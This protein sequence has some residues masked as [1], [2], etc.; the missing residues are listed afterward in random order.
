MNQFKTIT[1]KDGSISLD[2]RVSVE[3]G[4]IWLSAMDLA[5]LLNINVSTVR[6]YINL[7]YT[8]NCILPEQISANSTHFRTFLSNTKPIKLYDEQVIIELAAKYNYPNLG[9]LKD[10]I[11]EQKITCN[12]KDTNL[13]N[14]ESIIYNNGRLNLDV[15]I[16]PKEETVWLTQIQIAELF[17]TTQ[18]N[19]SMHIKNIINE[20][21]LE[22]NSVYKDFLYTA[23]DGKQYLMTFY[24]LDMI[25]AIGYRIKGKR[26]IEFRKWVSEVMKQYLIKGYALNNNR[27]SD[28]AES[29]IRLENEFVKLK[30]KVEDI[31]QSDNSKKEALFVNGQYYDSY[32]F[33][34]DIIEKAKHSILVIDPYFDNDSLKYLKYAKQ[35]VYKKVCLTHLENLDMEAIDMFKKQ[36]DPMNLFKIKK[37]HDRFMIIDKEQCYSLGTSLNKMGGK[38]FSIIKIENTDI[39]NLLLSKANK[40]KLI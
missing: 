29:L 18:P 23:S 27:L 19:V 40:A 20:G 33:I 4:T 28:Y 8:S 13:S 10:F 5:K 25:L 31:S 30:N 14:Q 12:N 11:N 38:V 24:N 9:V 34:K 26:A 36:Y 16:S 22:I 2:V 1:F 39:I 6:R 37:F 35:G 3:D 21:E 15:K 7:T 17:D 32:Q